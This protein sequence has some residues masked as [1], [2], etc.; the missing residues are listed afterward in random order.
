MNE[1][2]RLLA[3][4]ANTF[5]YF[6]PHR[7]NRQLYGSILISVMRLM[8]ATHFETFFL[9]SASNATIDM[10]IKKSLSAASYSLVED[11]INKQLI[12]IKNISFEDSEAQLSVI[13]LIYTCKSMLDD[14]TLPKDWF[15]LLILRDK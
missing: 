11:E 4:L 7:E 13:K 3:N 5:L 9:N 1:V 14:D 2:S 10:L 12:Q 15:D 8:E 6:K